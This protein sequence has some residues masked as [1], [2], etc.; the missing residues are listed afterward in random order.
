MRAAYNAERMRPKPPKIV[1][2]WRALRFRFKM[3]WLA[4]VKDGRGL[5]GALNAFLTSNLYSDIW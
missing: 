1:R 5:I 4:F 2:R 3:A